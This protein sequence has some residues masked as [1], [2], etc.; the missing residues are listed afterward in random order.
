MVGDVAAL[1]DRWVT[2][3]FLALCTVQDLSTMF[4]VLPLSG[5]FFFF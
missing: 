1:S 2:S 4:V 3:A 5:A